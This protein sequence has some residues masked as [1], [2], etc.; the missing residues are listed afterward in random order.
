MAQHEWHFGGWR[1]GVQLYRSVL[2]LFYF[3]VGHVENLQK[4]IYIYIFNELALILIV[5]I[6][7]AR[8]R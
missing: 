8:T 1:S 5:L 2:F 4:Y 3:L 7:S 6:L